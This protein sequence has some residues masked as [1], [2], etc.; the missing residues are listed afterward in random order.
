[1][2]RVSSLAY[3]YA[4]QCSVCRVWEN[5]PTK[6]FGIQ[7]SHH[8]ST[9]SISYKRL[10]VSFVMYPLESSN[11]TEF[12]QPIF[13]NKKIHKTFHPK[14]A[15]QNKTTNFLTCPYFKTIHKTSLSNIDFQ[16]KKIKT[17]HFLSTN[18]LCFLFS[19]SLISSTERLSSKQ[20][21]KEQTLTIFVYRVLKL[22]RPSKIYF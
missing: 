12:L 21:Y 8:E 7:L 15:F 10:H 11:S 4:I 19:F 20:I 16:N 22:I 18:I 3:N 2:I 6:Y 14:M 13:S 9:V 5:K 17:T 1:M